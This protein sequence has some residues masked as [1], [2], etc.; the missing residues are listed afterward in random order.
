M[1]NKD[2]ENV[3][4][5]TEAV[6]VET[7]KKIDWKKAGKKA[8]NFGIK[9]GATMTLACAAAYASNKV[10]DYFIAKRA[11]AGSTDH[12]DLATDAKSGN[13]SDTVFAEF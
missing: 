13:E 10:D 2:M 6:E 7:K 5:D 12:L 4:V 1:E 8:L 3:V 9:V 11:N